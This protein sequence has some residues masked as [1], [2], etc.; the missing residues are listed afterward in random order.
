[1]ANDQPT[2]K[3][4]PVNE[5]FS[6]YVANLGANGEPPDAASYDEIRE[7]VRSL[8]V[9]EMRRRSL[10]H[11]PPAFLGVSGTSWGQGALDELVTDTYTFIFIAACA[12]CAI[13]S[14]CKGTS[15]R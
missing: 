3:I 13:N 8:L 1:M 4:E 10:W 2:S 9:V 14:G 11:A 7:S 5:V 15:V 12:V 6:D